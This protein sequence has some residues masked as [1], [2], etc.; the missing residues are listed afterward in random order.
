MIMIMKMKIMMW[1]C[2]HD[3]DDG[4]DDDDDDD[5]LNVSAEEGHK[6]KDERLATPN[7]SQHV[8]RAKTFETKSE[9]VLKMKLRNK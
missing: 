4:D 6:L 1:S 5:D 7:Q 8:S 9:K 3:D 2:C